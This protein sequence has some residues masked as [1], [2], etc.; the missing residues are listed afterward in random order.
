[1]QRIDHATTAILVKA[2][3]SAPHKSEQRNRIFTLFKAGLISRQTMRNLFIAF[4]LEA[5]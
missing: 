4:E 2:A 5:E 1:M 3:L